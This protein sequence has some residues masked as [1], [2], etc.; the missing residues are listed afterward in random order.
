MDFFIF[1]EPPNSGKTSSLIIFHIYLLNQLGYTVHNSKQFNSEVKFV[2]ET[3]TKTRKILIWSET[4]QVGSI[5]GLR[6]YLKLHS[7]V[8][9]A[10]IASRAEGDRMRRYL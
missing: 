7:D 10:I 9:T 2:L 4:D 6:D 8:D 3:S 5:N 1:S